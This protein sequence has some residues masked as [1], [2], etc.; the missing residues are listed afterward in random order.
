MIEGLQVVSYM[1]LFDLKI[2]GNVHGF[3][4][5]FAD[6]AN[7]EILDTEAFTN[8]MGYYPE[9]DPFNLNFQNA[10]FVNNLVISNLGSLFYFGVGILI[11]TAIKFNLYLLVKW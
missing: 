10:G 2:P 11:L 4:S 3:I 9:M 6:L 8:E 7:F 5:F 1:P